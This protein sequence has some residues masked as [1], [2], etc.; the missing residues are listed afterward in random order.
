MTPCLQDQH[1]PTRTA[2]HIGTQSRQRTHTLP[3][4]Y[5]P[6]LPLPLFSSALP[7]TSSLLPTTNVHNRWHTLISLPHSIFSSVSFL[8][9][10]LCVVDL[11]QFT[12]PTLLPLTHGPTS[13]NLNWDISGYFSG[14]TWTTRVE[15]G[16]C[17][18]RTS[19]VSHTSHCLHHRLS[20][21]D[22]TCPDLT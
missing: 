3:I 19:P 6:I 16:A 2:E 4:L 13:D 20:C 9:V 17:F 1:K 15:L 5:T 11:Y 18:S 7:T 22:L 8:S 12:S 14:I 21:P 10:S